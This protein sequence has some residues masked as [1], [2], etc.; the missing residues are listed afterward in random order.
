MSIQTSI[1][2]FRLIAERSD[3]YAGQLGPY[4]CGQNGEWK[5]VW[6][7]NEHPAAAKV[8]VLRKD[9]AEPLWAVARFDA[10]VQMVK[11]R[12]TGAEEEPNRM[13]AQMGDVM[14]A[15]CAESLALRRAFPQELAG[16]YTTDEMAQ[17]HTTEVID[18][19]PSAP[20]IDA[21]APE[22]ERPAIAGPA[23]E[24]QNAPAQPVPTPQPTPGPAEAEKPAP[25]A[26]RQPRARR[27]TQQPTPI[28]QQGLDAAQLQRV[29]DVLNAHSIPAQDLAI[30]I[31]EN[32]GEQTNRWNMLP[33]QYTD[34][35]DVVL[36]AEG[37][38]RKD[39]AVAEQDAKKGVNAAWSNL[40]A[41]NAPSMED[42][43]FPPADT[44]PTPVAPVGDGHSNYED[45][46]DLPF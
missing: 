15:K 37:Q 16:L 39:A 12:E 25:Q 41:G 45:P 30:I 40:P 29:A 11:N 10:Y 14:I 42:P 31:K 24:P 35:V 17:A 13:W 38:K 27:E 22:T 1:D 34:L 20:A 5:D 2:G 36:P 6:L 9:F 26:A 21:P 32:W 8:A 18:A 23:P 4:W 43:L 28:N 44:A 33:W 3:H 19:A 46:D 7:S